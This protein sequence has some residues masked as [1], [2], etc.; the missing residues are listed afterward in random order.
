MVTTVSVKVNHIKE[1]GRELSKSLQDI[2]S[3]TLNYA[4]AARRENA[5]FWEE[6]DEEHG[7][8]Y[9]FVE[10]K[11]KK[12]IRNERPLSEGR[13]DLEDVKRV[14][15]IAAEAVRKNIENYV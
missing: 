4:D 14:A 10:I 7:K 1:P 13:Y 9:I 8:A 2:F 11:G 5:R 15:D 12:S 3:V 6:V